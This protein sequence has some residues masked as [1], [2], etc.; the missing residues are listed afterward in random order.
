M[1]KIACSARGVVV[2]ICV[3]AIGATRSAMAQELNVLGGKL[4][5]SI[6]GA[7]KAGPPVLYTPQTL[8]NYID[9]GA[10]L[11]LS[12]NFKGSLSQKIQGPGSG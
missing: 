12:Y 7:K 3:L 2:L 8:S 10:E 11:Y 9:G 1:V 6:G 5:D 4:P